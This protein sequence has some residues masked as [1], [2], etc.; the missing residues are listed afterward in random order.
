M[1]I[2]ETLQRS[3]NGWLTGDHRLYGVWWAGLAWTLVFAT[4]CAL[5]FTVIRIGLNATRSGV[6]PQMWL[7][8]FQANMVIS[9]A[10]AMLAISEPGCSNEKKRDRS[11]PNAHFMPSG[12]PIA[13]PVSGTMT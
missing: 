11:T 2:G 13:T 3:W 1:T 8:W 10:R 7:S 5:G 4:A 6:H 12:Q 9:A